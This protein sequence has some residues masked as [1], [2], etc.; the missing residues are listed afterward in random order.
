MSTPPPPIGKTHDQPRHCLHR[1]NP[2]IRTLTCVGHAPT[3]R[4]CKQQHRKSVLRYSMF[5]DGC[6]QPHRQIQATQP[7][8]LVNRQRPPAELSIEETPYC[9]DQKPGAA[10]E[11]LS[12]EYVNNPKPRTVET[13]ALNTMHTKHGAE[14]VVNVR[15]TEQTKRHTAAYLY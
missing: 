8:R 6:M 13:P 3:S 5:S 2:S 11:K 15:C 14:S 9:H 7:E 1:L 12:S 4:G 10:H